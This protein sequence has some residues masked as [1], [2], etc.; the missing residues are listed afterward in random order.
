LKNGNFEQKK[1]ETEFGSLN[2]ETY[3]YKELIER[4]EIIWKQMLFFLLTKK[5]FSFI[6]CSD[7]R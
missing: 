7:D 1:I 4:E 5:P 6:F 2:S 3:T